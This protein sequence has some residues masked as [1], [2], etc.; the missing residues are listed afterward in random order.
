MFDTS[1]NFLFCIFGIP[2][3]IQIGTLVS[4]VEIFDLGYF[5]VFVGILGFSEIA[6]FCH[7]LYFFKG[8]INW[9]FARIIGILAALRLVNRVVTM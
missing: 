1:V 3:F 9:D 2:D 4:S 6:K 8:F 7:V 5:C